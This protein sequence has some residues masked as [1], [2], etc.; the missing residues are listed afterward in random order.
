MNKPRQQHFCPKCHLKNFIDKDGYVWAIPQS[1]QRSQYKAKPE[2]VAKERDFYTLE[3]E[4]ELGHDPYILEKAFAGIEGKAERVIDKIITAPQTLASFLSKEEFGELLSFVGL[5]AARTPAIRKSYNGNTKQIS[6]LLMSVVLANKERFISTAKKA[7]L[8]EMT[9][10][11]Y[12]RLKEFHQRDEYDIKSPQNSLLQNLLNTASTVTNCL[13]CRN[14]IL[15]KSS[16]YKF[17][18]SDNPV[19]LSWIE[20]LYPTRPPGFGLSN[21]QVI[22]P[23]TPSLC[24]IG[25][26]EDIPAGIIELEEID[27]PIINSIIASRATNYLYSSEEEISWMMANDKIGGLT[28]YLTSRTVAATPSVESTK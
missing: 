27:V 20:P 8:G 2:N 3:V 14:W 4:D 7:G 5:F 17:I 16:K 21:T 26:F 24:L 22:L 13:L 10:K 15:G 23:L 28:D 11:D 12:Y 19:I 6:K 18:S 1:T 9:D 25:V